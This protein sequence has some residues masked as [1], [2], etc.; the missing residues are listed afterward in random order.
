MN[1]V[2]AVCLIV[3][4]GMEEWRGRMETAQKS[5]D[6]GAA[7][8]VMGEIR[9]ALGTDANPELRLLFAR[10]LLLTAE[11]CRT[12]FEVLSENGVDKD[13]RR[14]LGDKIDALAKEGMDAAAALGEVSEHYRIR[15][16]FYGLMI[17]SK[18]QG[19]KYRNKLESSSAKALELDPKNPYAYVSVSRPYL[20]AGPHQGGDL[21]KAMELL[22]KAIELKP[23]YEAA[24][25]LRAVGYEK[26][27][28]K[29]KSDE[30][31]GKILAKHPEASRA[32]K[33]LEIAGKVWTEEDAAD[34]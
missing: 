3:C 27:G 25:Q 18:Y 28:E 29:A 24:L 4:G 11:L 1:A 20:F 9:T 8:A 30:E 22:N 5:Y 16:D 32:R 15:S 33:T 26:L 17:R 7:E 10:S 31:W 21:K 14:A 2:F 6:I 19:K 34:S 12:D 13:K 23:D